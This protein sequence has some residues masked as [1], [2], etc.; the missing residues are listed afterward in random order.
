MNQIIEQAQQDD[1]ITTF[2]NFQARLAQ[3][4]Q[5]KSIS[6]RNATGVLR[7]EIFFQRLESWIRYS[8]GKSFVLCLIELNNAEALYR[9]HGS[10]AVSEVMG[11]IGRLL[12]RSFG[13]ADI[14]GRYLS[15]SFIVAFPGVASAQCRIDVQKVL[16]EI[17]SITFHAEKSFSVSCSA[18]MSQHLLDEDSVELLCKSAERKLWIASRKGENQLCI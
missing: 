3:L 13:I 8:R 10:L 11:T 1:V 12:N 5:L 2:Q 16:D 17:S 9:Q 18:G 4:R 14:R 6:E 7:R 15:N